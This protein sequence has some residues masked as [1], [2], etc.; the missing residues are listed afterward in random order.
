MH[1]NPPRFVDL[2]RLF[3]RIG[4]LSFGGPAGQIALMQREL[5]DQRRWIAPDRYAH[6]LNFCMLLPGPEAQQLA[7]YCG[8]LLHGVRGGLAAGLLF[9]L[10]G[11]AV[12]LAL[13]F[14]YVTV[15]TTG[16]AQGILYGVKA[17]VFAVVLEALF[18]VAKR[19]LKRRSDWLIAAA[20]FVA[21]FVFHLPFPLIILVAGLIGYMRAPR[22]SVTKNQAD[23]DRPEHRPV[24]TAG[25]G[26]VL[27]AAPVLLLLAIFGQTAVFTQLSLFFSKMAVVTFGGAY[28]V[29]SYVAQEA[30]QTRHWLTAPEM[31]DGLGLAETTPGPLILVLQHVGFLAGWRNHL[32]VSPVMGGLLGAGVTTWVTFVPSFLWI[33]IGAPYVER[34]RS[35]VKLSGALSGI[36][37]AVV[38]V[39]FNMALWFGL[40]IVFRQMSDVPV[41]WGRL[42]LPVFNSFDPAA[43]ALGG[44]AAWLLLVRHTGLFKVLALGAALGF[45]WQQIF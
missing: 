31:I 23:I 42:V 17:V 40:H 27:W 14:L 30:V 4:C 36:T 16:A 44:L 35:N 43:A 34:L 41:P 12:M 39:I 32:G 6:A 28:A 24:L 7:T 10:P 25:I 18:R 9:I 20:A 21:L 15:G 3:A 8:W 19:S 45:A 2:V 11:A 33:L 1:A 22:G 29:L 5:V 26:L 38:G 13:S 37:A